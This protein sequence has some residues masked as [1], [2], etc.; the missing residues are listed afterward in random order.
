MPLSIVLRNI[1][2]GYVVHKDL[3]K[4]NHLLYL[5]DIKL[6]AKSRPELESLLHSVE[7]FS[8]DI[9]MA[10]GFEK[11]KTL[12]MARGK[13]IDGLDISLLTG[14]IKHLDVGESYR[15][16]GILEAEVVYHDTM[17]KHIVAKYKRRV[18]KMLSSYLNSGNAIVAI[19]SLAVPILRY[20]AG[21]VEW[22]QADF[23][24]LDVTTRKLLSLYRAFNINSDVDRLYV[25]RSLG[26]RGLLSIADTV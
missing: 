24:K 10:F 2:K 8:T 16:L 23:Y 7:I 19:N 20:S 9:C 12:S 26:G 4:V 22:T 25:H 6:Y 1:N 13:F 21:L 3:Q 17:K 5:D 18:R 15:Y 11:C 14:Q